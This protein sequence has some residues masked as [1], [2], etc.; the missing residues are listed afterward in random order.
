MFDREELTTLIAQRCNRDGDSLPMIRQRLYDTFKR[1]T[2]VVRFDSTEHLIGWL[3]YDITFDGLVHVRKII[4]RSPGVLTSMVGE[5]KARLPW[6][7]VYFYRAK[8]N[9]WRHH[10]NPW[11]LRHAMA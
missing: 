6:K 11:S 5:L 10:G 4:A 1:R 3:D 8:L 7:R 2:Y 9:R